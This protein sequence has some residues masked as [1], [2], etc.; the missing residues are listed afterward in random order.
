MVGFLLV[1]ARWC[2]VRGRWLVLVAALGIVGFV[3]LARTE[4]S[5]LRAAAMG[6]VGLLAMGAN[7]RRRATRGLG[8]AVVVLLLVQPGLA[9]SA[10]FV[11]SVLATAGIVLLAPGWRDAMARWLPR[12]LAEAVAVPA[13]AQVACT[14]VVAAHLGAGQPG[15]GAGQPAGGAGGRPGHGA[16]AWPAGWSGCVAPPVGRLLGTGAGVVRGLDRRGRPARRRPAAGRRRL[17]HRR[18]VAGGAHRA[19]AS[20]LALAGAGGAALGPARRCRWRCW[21][22]W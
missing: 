7:G 3:L 18:L 8:V 19:A 6:T 16:R 14:P 17:G 13:A 1:L 2:R 12:W 20:V 5:V 4:P 9:V 22:S 15:R 10:G 11:L 21:R